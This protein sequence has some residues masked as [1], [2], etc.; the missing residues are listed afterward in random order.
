VPRHNGIVPTDGVAVCAL[1]CC[2]LQHSKAGSGRGRRGDPDRR[3]VMDIAFF[4]SRLGFDISFGIRTEGVIASLPADADRARP[5]RL[6][7]PKRSLSGDTRM[8]YTRHRK[9]DQE[10]RRNPAVLGRWR[11][12]HP[13]PPES[14]SLVTATIAS[15]SHRPRVGITAEPRAVGIAA[16]GSRHPAGTDEKSKIKSTVISRVTIQ[17][18]RLHHQANRRPIVELRHYRW[19]IYRKHF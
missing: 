13:S 1:A 5:R 2:R 16:V 15:G 17:P 12:V 19:V 8:G 7:K 9:T 3:R 4:G 6:V 11:R 10:G 14:P 18:T